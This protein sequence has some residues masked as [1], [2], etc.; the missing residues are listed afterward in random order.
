MTPANHLWKP[1]NARCIQIDGFVPTP[2]GPQIPVSKSL[3]WPAK[4]PGDT[5]DYVFDI[6]SALTANP[7][8]MI[9][10][11]DVAISPN[12]PGDVMLVS[13]SADGPR[14]V[15]W[16]S[17]GQALTTY[18]VTIS[19]T[20]AGGRALVRS[21]SLPVIALASVSVPESALTTPNGQA[22]TDATG[23]SLTTN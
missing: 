19:I 9:S 22:L 2:R 12:N 1:S 4:D 11:L 16:L 20:T 5:L 10:T 8:D 17:R 21:I 3:V 13:S 23:T 6:S 15:L 7:G 18:T 14:A